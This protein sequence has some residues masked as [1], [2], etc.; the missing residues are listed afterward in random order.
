M[1]YNPKTSASNSP[2]LKLEQLSNFGNFLLTLTNLKINFLKR[3]LRNGRIACYFSFMCGHSVDF[4]LHVSQS[5]LYQ[6]I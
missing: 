3:N 4:K 5:L 6:I 2:K 1:A